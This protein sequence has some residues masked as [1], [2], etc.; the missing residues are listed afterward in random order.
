MSKYFN[1]EKPSWAGA[2]ACAQQELENHQERIEH[3]KGRVKTIKRAIR[4][5]QKQIKDGE[6]WIG[7]WKLGSEEFGGG[8]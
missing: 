8:E 2:T 5:F 3:H 7:D 6:P 4:F 1:E